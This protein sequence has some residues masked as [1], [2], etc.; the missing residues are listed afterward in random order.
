MSSTRMPLLL[1]TGLTGLPGSPGRFSDAAEIQKWIDVLVEHGYPYI[2]CARVYGNGTAEE[3][4]SK[5]DLKGSQVDTKILPQTPGDHAPEKLKTTFS[6]SL[7]ALGPNIKIRVF[8]LHAPDRSVPFEDTL[9]AVNDLYKQGLFHE[10]G[11][12][13]YMAFE[14][15]EIVGICK[16]RGFVP[17]T[18]YQGVYNMLFRGPEAELFPCLRKFGIKFAAYSVLAGG[19]LTGKYIDNAT[20]APGSHFDPNWR[21]GGFY[22]AR[23]GHAMQAIKKVKEIAEKHNLQLTDVAYR[24]LVHH[25]AMVPEDHGIIVGGNNVSQI[26]KAIV[27]CEKGPLPEEVVAVCEETWNEVKG[28]VTANYW[29]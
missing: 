10:F 17:P 27:E 11:L 18:V 9:E 4:L 7:A 26:E 19:L 25:S 15:A 20:P 13:N 6:L 1:G 22:A 3:L 2:D 12:S 14:V 21:L 24:W 29:V 23:F 16:R 5:L 8:Y 28:A